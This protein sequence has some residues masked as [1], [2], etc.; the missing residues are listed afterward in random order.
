MPFQHRGLG[1]EMEIIDDQHQA[2]A[3][4]VAHQTIGKKSALSAWIC[5]QG[6]QTEFVRPGDRL[7]A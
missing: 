7:T 6:I 4:P 1:Q 2:Q 3:D 5:L